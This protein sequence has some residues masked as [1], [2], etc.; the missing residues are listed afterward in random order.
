MK[1]AFDLMSVVQIQNVLMDTHLKSSEGKI[2]RKEFEAYFPIAE[3]TILRVEKLPQD[4][5]AGVYYKAAGELHM[6]GASYARSKELLLLASALLSSEVTA[7]CSNLVME[8]DALAAFCE[9]N[10]SGEQDS[11]LEFDLPGA[12]KE[13]NDFNPAPRTEEITAEP[14]KI[15]EV[16]D[17]EPEITDDG[18]V[19]EEIET[20]DKEEKAAEAAAAQLAALKKQL[21]EAVAAEDY[22]KAAELQKV[23]KELQAAQAAQAAEDYAK[24][25]E[26][27]KVIKELQ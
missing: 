23:I 2:I 14:P 12:K 7:D 26:L 22:A 1:D 18:V 9:R 8:C 11:P 15:E 17:D 5:N 3:N 6:W 13:S 24:A 16:F 27:Q 4:G 19:I 21:A 20:P 25:A 10:L